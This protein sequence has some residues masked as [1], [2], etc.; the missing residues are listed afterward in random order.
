MAKNV[1]TQV[2]DHINEMKRKYDDKVRVQ[3]LQSL[4]NGW[5]V[6]NYRFIVLLLNLQIYYQDCSFEFFSCYCSFIY[7]I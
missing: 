5:E 2:A 6:S 7:F 3:E 1:M 4:L